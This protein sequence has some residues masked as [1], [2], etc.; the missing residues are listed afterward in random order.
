MTLPASGT[1][2]MAQ[3]RAEFG[4]AGSTALNG[5]YRGGTLVPNVPANSG[6]PTSGA[7]S[8][9]NF[10]NASGA[11]ISFSAPT[12]SFSFTRPSG[13]QV[14]VGFEITG[15]GGVFKLTGTNSIGTSSTNIGSWF[16]GAG[17]ANGA[18]SVMFTLSSGTTGGS[19]FGSDAAIGSWISIN[20]TQVYFWSHAI[21]SGSA[22]TTGLVQI[23]R[24]SDMTIVS[25]TNISMTV[26][27]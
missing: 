27:F 11:T 25:S 2:T 21:F 8:L 26:I 16:T 24:N 7:I 12:Y 13:V 17:V 22:T 1:I 18:Y 10:Y 20:P 9:S 3:I 23:R 15:T 19:M 6:I 4:G 14:G 5:Y